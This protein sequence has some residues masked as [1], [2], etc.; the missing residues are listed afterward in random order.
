MAERERPMSW[1]D[2]KWLH[3]WP[4][5]TSIEWALEWLVYWCKG[6]AIFEILEFIGRASVLIAVILWF[7]EAENRK[8]QKHYRA[9]ELINSARGSTGDGGRRNALQDLNNDGVSLAAVPLANAYLYDV[10]LPKAFLLD[11]DLSGAELFGADLSMAFLSRANMTKA[12]LFDANLSGAELSLVN[13]S[14]A[15]LTGA[16][17]SRANLSG[18]TLEGASLF[19]T[20]LSETHLNKVSLLKTSLSMTNLENAKFCKTTMPD[21]TLNNRDCPPEPD[22]PNPGEPS[23]D[24]N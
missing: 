10:Q 9:W 17:L 7:W 4:R 2:W 16:D 13:L 11:A 19:R 14:E 18:A 20:N 15:D 8:K 5:L 1:E 6:L 3:R 21:G 24:P 12:K 22:L 23:T